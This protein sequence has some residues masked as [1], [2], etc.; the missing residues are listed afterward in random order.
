V[1]CGRDV[2]YLSLDGTT[3]KIRWQHEWRVP[4]P[5][6]TGQDVRIDRA[7]DGGL[8]QVYLP[9]APAETQF[10]VFD[11]ET[12]AVV[13]APLKLNL[14]TS[15]IGI[16]DAPDGRKLWDVRANHPVATESG[17][18]LQCALDQKTLLRAGLLC[19]DSSVTPYVKDGTAKL[20]IVRF[21]ETTVRPLTVSLGGPFAVQPSPRDP[22]VSVAVFGAVVG[23]TAYQPADGHRSRIVGLR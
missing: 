16:V 11:T 8:V 12:G 19:A 1:G 20:S 5:Q 6:Y 18:V 21:G 2:R 14:R 23:Y 17:D 10:T 4:E 15:G 13:P 22:F 3:G 9:D 7:T